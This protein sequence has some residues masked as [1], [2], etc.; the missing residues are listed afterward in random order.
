M[1]NTPVECIGLACIRYNFDVEGTTA[2]Y[3]FSNGFDTGV[4]TGA[5][6][7][8][9]PLPVDAQGNVTVYLSEPVDTGDVTGQGGVVAVAQLN[10]RSNV[11]P[12]QGWT[13]IEYE[14]A[15]AGNYAAVDPQKAIKIGLWGVTNQLPAALGADTDIVIAVFRNG[16][17]LFVHT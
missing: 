10:A 12:A 3:V 5:V 14:P 8:S 16:Q 15:Q 6:A 17:T 7:G 1:L 13:T 2:A 4:P 9:S 11:A